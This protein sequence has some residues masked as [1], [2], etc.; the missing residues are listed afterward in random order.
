MN[1]FHKQYHYVGSVKPKE[2][3]QMFGNIFTGNAAVPRT[4][5]IKAQREKDGRYAIRILPIMTAGTP[6]LQGHVL[7]RV[8]PTIEDVV[9][10]VSVQMIAGGGQIEEIRV[11]KTV[12]RRNDV[13]VI[14][15]KYQD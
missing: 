8:V 11:T 2:V 15:N 10:R 1:Q 6:D 13:Y 3:A 9:K 14:L 5:D 4:E 7:D 12:C